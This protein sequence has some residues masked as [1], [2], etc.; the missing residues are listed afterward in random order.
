MPQTVRRPV[1]AIRPML[2]AQNTSNVGVVKHPAK[3]S[4]NRRSE[5]GRL[6]PGSI[7]GSLSATTV[8]QELSML[9]S[10]HPKITHTQ[11]TSRVTP[12]VDPS[13]KARKSSEPLPA[14]E[15]ETASETQLAEAIKGSLDGLSREEIA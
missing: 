9:P 13:P 3:A 2:K 6:T 4:N 10:S 7:D 8:V 12:T 15:V 14:M 5:M 11:V 1:C